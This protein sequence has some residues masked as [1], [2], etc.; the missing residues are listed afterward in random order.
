MRLLAPWLAL[1]VLLNSGAALR[2]D[3]DVRVHVKETQE[4]SHEQHAGRRQKGPSPEALRSILLSLGV[5]AEEL[6]EDPEQ[7]QWQG[8][9]GVYFDED[10]CVRTLNFNGRPISGRLDALAN[11][12]SL[13][14]LYLADTDVTGSLQALAEMSELRKLWLR[15]T[16]VAGDLQPLSK[17]TK[18]KQLYLQNTGVTGGLQALSDMSELR[19]LNLH[20][21][22]VAGDLQPL[23]K[24]TKLKQIL[25]QN[26]GVTGSLQGLAEMTELRKLWLHGSKVAGD[27]QPLSKLTKL[28]ELLLANTGVTGSLQALAE[29]PELQEL[30]LEG[31]KVVGDLQPLFKLTKLKLLLLKNTDV[32]GSLQALAEMTE[33]QTLWLDGTK[34]A[35]DLQPL[36]K[37]TMLKQLLLMNTGVTGSLQALAEM[38]E[39]RKLSLHGTKVAGDLQ[40]LSKLTKL[41]ELLLMNT[42]VN[43]SL[44]PLGDMSDLQQLGL[45]GTNV[46]G[47][48]QPVSKLTKLN[49]LLLANTGVTGSLQPLAEMS[50]LRKLWLR[51][52]KVAGDLQTVA[53]LTKLKQLSLKNTVVDGDFCELLH[54]TN[55]EQADLS[56]THVSGRLTPAWRGQLLQLHTLDLKG[57]QVNFL[58]VGSDLKDL[59]A[60]FV[61]N[62]TEQ[63][64]PA[65]VNLDVSLCPLDGDL[66]NLLQPLSF[67]GH[68]ASIRAS[69]ANL[70]GHLQKSC[71]RDVSVDG[72]RY[73]DYCTLPLLSSLQGLELA[74]NKIHHIEGIPANVYVSLANNSETYVSMKSLR[75]A[76]DRNVQVDLTATKISNT[77]DVAALFHEE[78]LHRTTQLTQSDRLKGFECYGI[79]ST[80]LRVSPAS[81]WPEGLCA[82]TAGFQGNG[83]LC[84]KC[85]SNTYNER[86]NGSCVPCPSNSSTAEAGASSVFSCL[87]T[88]G[89]MYT[90]ESGQH[91]QCDASKALYQ[92]LGQKRSEDAQ[93]AASGDVCEDCGKLRLD[94]RALGSSPDCGRHGLDA[95]S[96]PPQ[97]GY[98]RLEAGAQRAYR[99]LE[100]TAEER[101]NA[102]SAN[103]TGPGAA[104][105]CTTGHEGP[106][107]V[108]CSWGYRSRAGVCVPCEVASD[109]QKRW[110]PGRELLYLRWVVGAAVFAAVLAAVIFLWRRSR[111]QPATARLEPTLWSGPVL[112]QLFQLWGLL[113]ALL[114]SQK[115]TGGEPARADGLWAEEC[116]QWLQLTAQGL[117]DATSLECWFGRTANDVTALVGPCV[118]LG[119]LVLCILPELAS[120][121]SGSVSFVL[122]L[123][124]LLYI[125]GAS[126]SAALMRCQHTDGGKEP[127]PDKHAFRS[128]LPDIKCQDAAPLADSI[129]ATCV[130]CYGLLIPSFLAYLMFKQHLALAPSRRFVSLVAQKEGGD[131]VSVWPVEESEKTEPERDKELKRKSLLAA[132]VA[133]SCIYFAGGVRVQLQDERLILRPQEQS[134]QEHD[135]N[136]D[137]SSFVWTALGNKGDADLRRCQ[138]LERMLKERYVLDE[139]ASS[140]RI[141]AGAK[142]LFV[143]YAACQNVWFEIAMRIVAVALVAAVRSEIGLEFTLGF[144][145]CTALAIATIR[146]FRQHQVNDLQSFCFFCSPAFVSSASE[147]RES[148]SAGLAIAAFAFSTGRVLTARAALLAPCV[149]AAAQTLK[150][151]GPEALA[152]R[153]FQDSG[154]TP[155]KRRRGSV[156]FAATGRDLGALAAEHQLAL[157]LPTG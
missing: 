88:V 11:L 27:L 124:T 13:Q 22:K 96:A 115:K 68:L 129:A 23:L 147:V 19:Y 112:L 140:D 30:W 95:S 122:K 110:P 53:K 86:F 40:P 55:L 54:L 144:T 8:G 20:D 99:C 142:E 14:C 69:G 91:C 103:S 89:R 102:S 132:A 119:L 78:V 33:M 150:P 71:L 32:T 79:T 154:V 4:D 76:L 126:S 1:A 25:L 26:T 117:R 85:Q 83:T 64:L 38:T 45:H 157:K 49:E 81:F 133:R 17:L 97:V 109:A 80:S 130:V 125:G 7:W 72:E 155:V 59:R 141:V 143:K 107:C 6:P 2:N 10:G 63:V 134:G 98:A 149:M 34:V 131:T 5:P 39:L 31:T 36:S 35:G 24:L 106:L 116:V 94:R 137:A 56:G 105:G 84:H 120:H 153:L 93:T 41:E 73:S 3:G 66:Q 145:L 113:V 28:K 48:L 128:A 74:D 61:T 50:E 70:S 118:P 47:D 82:C 92:I 18:L 100:P 121:G 138:A 9:Q 127:L 152:L 37:L 42:G 123:L 51:G 29:M 151:D 43:G 90:S 67:A 46:A 65:L 87:C 62:Q 101:C 21:T 57:S 12:T 146:P 135:V 77:D 114:E 136:L 16:K 148:R 52:T 139:V 15:G 60:T 58:P 104:L 111:S 156:A 44:Q 75:E 108:A